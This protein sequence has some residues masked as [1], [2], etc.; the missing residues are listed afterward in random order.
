MVQ[1]H[2]NVGVHFVNLHVNIVFE[3]IIFYPRGRG[4]YVLHR[5][6]S[7]TKNFS[8]FLSP[9]GFNT[10]KFTF[11]DILIIEFEKRLF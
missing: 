8:F 7:F 5:A 1:T 2:F 3:K 10:T 4:D 11:Y 9:D 6:L